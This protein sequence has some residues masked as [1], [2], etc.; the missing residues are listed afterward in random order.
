[1]DNRQIPDPSQ[2]SAV[3]RLK[4]YDERIGLGW[5]YSSYSCSHDR[6]SFSH[7]SGLNVAVSWKYD[8]FQDHITGKQEVPMKT[9]SLDLNK[10]WTSLGKTASP[11]SLLYSIV[12]IL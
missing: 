5:Y 1:M 8:S 6:K 10:S 11:R 2:F 9:E 7:I 4:S 3:C 12:S